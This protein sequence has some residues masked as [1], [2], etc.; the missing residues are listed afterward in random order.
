MFCFHMSSMVDMEHMFVDGMGINPGSSILT[1][2]AS[3]RAPKVLDGE[4]EKERWIWE[5]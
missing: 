1:R 4:I 2:E 3:Q 5:K